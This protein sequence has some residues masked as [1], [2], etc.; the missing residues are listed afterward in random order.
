MIIWMLW[1]YTSWWY[2]HSKQ[3]SNQ[4]AWANNLRMCLISVQ[5]N[6]DGL[7]Q[8]CSISIAGELEILQSCTK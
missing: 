3:D 5:Y 6:I 4:P 2:L 7:V 8:D 1:L